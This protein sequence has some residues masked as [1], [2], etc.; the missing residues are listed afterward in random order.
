MIRKFLF[1]PTNGFAKPD[2]LSVITYLDWWCLRGWLVAEKVGSILFKA[3]FQ[4]LVLW[5][6]F[7]VRSVDVLI[8]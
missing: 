8:S 3:V 2:T 1:H 4:S 5:W 6:M 7:C